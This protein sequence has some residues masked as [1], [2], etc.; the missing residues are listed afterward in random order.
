MY[1]SVFSDELG[2]D[3]KQALPIF[4]DLG[5]THVDLRALIN[6]KGI[7]NQ[8]D[9]ELK[10][11]K[12]DLKAY[13]LVPTVLQ[14]SLCKV[15]LPS[16]ER[17]KLEMEKLEGLIRAA[18]ILECPMV[19]SFNFWQHKEGEEGLGEL[20]M[21]PDALDRVMELYTPFVDRAKEAGLIFGIENCGQTPDEVIALLEAYN[22]P[23][24]GLAWDV[25]NMFE[26]LPEAQG[27]CIDYFTKALKYANMIHVKARSIL[28]EIEN[29]KVPWDRVLRGV[30]AT[31]KDMPISIETHNP[32]GSPLSKQ[33]ATEKVYHAIKKAMPASAPGSVAEAI[34]VKQKFERPYKDN[35]VKFVVVGLGMGKNRCAQIVDT[36]GI[37]LYGVCDTN[38]KRVKEIGEQFGVRYSDDIQ[39]FLNDPAVE[40]MYIV[41]PTGLHCS[42][43]EDCLR[44]GKHVLVT[45]P[46]DVCVENCDSAIKLANELGLMLGVDYDLHYRGPLT[47]LKK[48]MDAGWFGEIKG[49]NVDLNIKRSQ[50]YYNENGGW[51]GTWALDG[52]G[53]LSNQ[54]IHEIDRILTVMGMPKRV[55]ASIATQTFDIE[56]EDFGS[57]EWEYENGC[58]VRFM[59]NTSYVAS[60]WYTRIE[61]HGTRGAYLLCQG[62]PEGNHT[63]WFDGE[64]WSEDSPFKVERE[65][66]QGSDNFAYCVRT[67]ATPVVGYQNGR[68][69]RYVLD[70]MYES[71]KNGEAWVEIEV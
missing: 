1:I 21:R 43:A 37:E 41:T 46:M 47:E 49:I 25:A 14:S 36:S 18:D 30:A 26:T 71:A 6:G 23:G 66:Q 38:P 12:A 32:V 7:H 5:L 34:A 62:G 59:S 44:A 63:Y 61:L 4:A 64:K 68:N 33:E 65:W 24:W 13:G 31:G 45:K 9:E 11:L 69:A 54:G 17:V 20:A 29:K 60:S 10:L 2:L 48:A 55:K 53:A 15:H 42:I 56:A 70:K 19:R 28:P 50:K 8:T 52:G 67:G 51:R 57:T 35:P 3:Y 40:V 39:V 22:V 16:E 27:D 58:R